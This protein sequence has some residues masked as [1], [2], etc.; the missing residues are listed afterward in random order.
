MSYVLGSINET[1][2][3]NC[4]KLYC[5]S[6]EAVNDLINIGIV[7]NKTYSKQTKILLN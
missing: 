2:D 5:F 6:N 3:R 4:K 1:N 7:E